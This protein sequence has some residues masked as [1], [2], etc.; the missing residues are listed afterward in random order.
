MVVNTTADTTTQLGARDDIP[1][2]LAQL[3]EEARPNGDDPIG[4][5]NEVYGFK[6]E[7]IGNGIYITWTEDFNIS[8]SDAQILGAFTDEINNVERLPFQCKDGYVV[9][10][11]NMQTRRMTSTVSLRVTS[12]L[13]VRVMPRSSTT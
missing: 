8:V 4:V 3:I 1:D 10:I 11:A 13:M 9:K 2:P 7:V 12:V 5:G 6:T